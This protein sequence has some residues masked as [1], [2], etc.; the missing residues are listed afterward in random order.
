MF[1]GFGLKTHLNITHKLMPYIN[2]VLEVW[3]DLVQVP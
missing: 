2:N 3:I 1:C